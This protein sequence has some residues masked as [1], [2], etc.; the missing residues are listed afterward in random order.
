M[1]IPE[2]RYEYC[3]RIV[4]FMPREMK[5]LLDSLA[6]PCDCRLTVCHGWRLFTML[7]A[8]LVPAAWTAR[9]KERR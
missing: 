7:R 3:N 1:S 8:E 9:P 6:I 5:N 2:T 4:L